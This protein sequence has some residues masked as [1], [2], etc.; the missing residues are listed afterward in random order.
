VAWLEYIPGETITPLPERVVVRSL[1]DKRER[2][3]NMTPAGP[4][5]FVLLGVNAEAEELT[6]YEHKYATGKTHSP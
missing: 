3:V 1:Q 2:F 5:E 4:S 6:F